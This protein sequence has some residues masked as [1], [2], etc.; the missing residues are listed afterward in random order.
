MFFFC[1]RR[2]KLNHRFRIRGCVRT[3]ANNRNDTKTQGVI[4]DCHSWAEWT[5]TIHKTS[6]GSRHS[7]CK[8]NSNISDH[9]LCS[10]LLI[11]VYIVGMAE[12]FANVNSVRKWLILI[13][14]FMPQENKRATATTTLRCF[15]T[16]VHRTT[17]TDA[18]SLWIVNIFVSKELFEFSDGPLYIFVNAVC[19]L[20]LCVCVRKNVVCCRCGCL[21]K[22]C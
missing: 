1:I 10:L 6:E 9:C 19:I 16:L 20:C 2:Q 7:C 15:K 5:E 11:P 14:V 18:I 8:G 21:T 3:T 22:W 17:Q 12:W 13:L 4:H